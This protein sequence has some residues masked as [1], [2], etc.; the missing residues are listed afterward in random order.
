MTKKE[1]WRPVKGFENYYAIST[2]GRLRS[3]K[4]LK[5]QKDK[6]GYHIYRLSYLGKEKTV[7]IH[8]LVALAFI[9]PRFRKL[10]INHKDGRKDN[11]NYLNLEYVT[12]AENRRHAC[13][14]GLHARGERAGGAKLTV[15]A[16][17]DIRKRY[18]S[19]GVFQRELAAEYGVGRKNITKIVQRQR[20]G[21]I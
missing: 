13:T 19:G 21:H 16:V 14:L 6:D 8:Q 18:A 3:Y 2:W 1:M 7:K 9:G 11:N 20:W 17:R 15:A 12:N 10:Q 5:L 4:I